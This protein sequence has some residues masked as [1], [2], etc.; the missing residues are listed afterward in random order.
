MCQGK[1]GFSV[2]AGLATPGHKSS[3]EYKTVI[4]ISWP[5]LDDQ[6]EYSKNI[7]F[8][9]NFEVPSHTIAIL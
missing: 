5:H 6:V 9:D 2:E 3:R 8:Q 4:Q 7:E 1:N